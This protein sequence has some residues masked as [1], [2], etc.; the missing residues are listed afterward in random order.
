MKRI[1]SVSSED[2]MTVKFPFY[3][4]HKSKRLQPLQTLEQCQDR[5]EENMV[6]LFSSD[7]LYESIELIERQQFLHLGEGQ[8]D[9]ETNSNRQS[10]EVQT[11]LQIQD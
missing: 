11:I 5:E 8:K 1:P 9:Q 6:N 2:K 7:Y 3:V 10:A 4:W